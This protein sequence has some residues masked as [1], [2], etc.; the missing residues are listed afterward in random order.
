A[1][2]R[3]ALDVRGVDRHRHLDGA[4]DPVAG[5]CLGSREVK[6]G[7]VGPVPAAGLDGNPLA[8]IGDHVVGSV[9]VRGP[10]AASGG[11]GQPPAVLHVHGDVAVG[12]LGRAHGHAHEL[13][14]DRPVGDGEIQARFGDPALAVADGVGDPAGAGTRG[15][16]ADAA[17]AHASDV[18]VGARAG[19][20]ADVQ[21]VAVDI[22]VVGEKP[23]GGVVHAVVVAVGSVVLDD[24]AVVDGVHGDLRDHLARKRAVKHPVDDVG[25]AV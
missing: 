13:G 20:T 23:R 2:G 11:D 14:R 19:D 5:P 9:R 24:R 16:P 6:T 8:G 15:L 18:H 12:A 4:G 10:G 22:D 7:G 17:A 21:G 25:G 3:V 1:R